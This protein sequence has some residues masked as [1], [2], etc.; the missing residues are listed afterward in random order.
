MSVDA[1]RLVNLCLS[2]HELWSL[3]AQ[4][5]VALWLLY[6]QAGGV[7]EC[8]GVRVGDGRLEGCACRCG[9]VCATVWGGLVGVGGARVGHR[10]GLAGPWML[11]VMPRP[12]A[13][14]GSGQPAPGLM[15][16][17]WAASRSHVVFRA[18]RRDPTLSPPRL[19]RR[20][21]CRCSTLSLRGWAWCCC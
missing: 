19:A 10:R 7:R 5:G 15:P 8:L 2:F 12:Q 9:R 14:V 17:L 4:I 6:T 18:R 13:W 11:E 3:P 21:A 16:G 1:D 20:P